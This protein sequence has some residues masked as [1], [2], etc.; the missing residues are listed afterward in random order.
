MKAGFVRRGG[1][2]SA[3]G[4][5]GRMKDGVVGR[6]GG[7]VNGGGEG[8]CNSFRAPAPLTLVSGS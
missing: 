1:S 2:V 7:S 5:E 6:G 3:G 8:S 4:G